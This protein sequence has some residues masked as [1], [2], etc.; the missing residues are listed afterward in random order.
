MCIMVWAREQCITHGFYLYI[1]TL[2]IGY[3]KIII[4]LNTLIGHNGVSMFYCRVFTLLDTCRTGYVLY[5]PD[6]VIV[7]G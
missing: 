1:S 3:R 6:T 7:A 2:L 4:R 5:L